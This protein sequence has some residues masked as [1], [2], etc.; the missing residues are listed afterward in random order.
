MKQQWE[1]KEG[2]MLW[3]VVSLKGLHSYWER[4]TSACIPHPG[5]PAFE[6]CFRWGNKP[7][8]DCSNLLKAKCH[9]ILSLG[10]ANWT[11]GSGYQVA[12]TEMSAVRAL[13][14]ILLGS[15][16]TVLVCTRTW[17]L[18][19]L[20]AILNKAFQRWGFCLFILVYCSQ[21]LTVHIR[22]A[23]LVNQLRQMSSKQ[24]Q[25]FS[26]LYVLESFKPFLCRKY[27]IQQHGPIPGHWH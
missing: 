26:S 10:A 6:E 13:T 18:I 17:E 1:G 19:W 4:P 24:K 20:K 9:L 3:Y 16:R 5:R 14:L 7:R 21:N 8:E 12:A 15:C 27:R 11:C 23:R 22:M 2:S 25:H